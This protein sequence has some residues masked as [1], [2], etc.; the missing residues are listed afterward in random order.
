MYKVFT[1]AEQDTILDWIES[2]AG[3]VP[4]PVPGPV[5]P[6]EAVHRIVTDLMDKGA[7]AA[8]HRQYQMKLADGRV[9][10]VAELFATGD[11]DQVMAAL[12]QS[13]Y[14]VKGD[15]ASSP[16][17]SRVFG[18]LMSGVLTPPQVSAFEQW[19]NLGCPMPGALLA[20]SLFVRKLAAQ[21]KEDQSVPAGL[22]NVPFAWRRQFI[23]TGSVH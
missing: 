19:V 3:S 4:P 8:Q 9:M 22:S 2:L 23:G 18:D 13:D 11:A 5:A 7:A 20:R 1:A 14:V 6:A 17:I 10:T 15:A 16:L 21:P 12:A